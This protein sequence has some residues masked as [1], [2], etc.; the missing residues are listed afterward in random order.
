VVNHPNCGKPSMALVAKSPE[1]AIPREEVLER[2]EFALIMGG[3][4]EADFDA[5]DLATMPIEELR[6]IVAGA[7]DHFDRMF[8]LKQAIENVI[9]DKSQHEPHHVIPVL[10]SL[11]IETC[12]VCEEPVHAFLDTLGELHDEWRRGAMGREIPDEIPA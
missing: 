7:P 6:Q 12:M 9:D 5:V 11:L 3:R 2:L 1:V 4:P 10:I 8:A